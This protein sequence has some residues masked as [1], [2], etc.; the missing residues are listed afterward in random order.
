MNIV[1]LPFLMF[2]D[3]PLKYADRPKHDPLSY[4]NRRLNAS[5]LLKVVI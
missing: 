5:F 3:K 2:M 1:V 4:A